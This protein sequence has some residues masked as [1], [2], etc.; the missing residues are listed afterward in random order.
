[1]LSNY[2]RLTRPIL[3][4]G[5]MIDTQENQWDITKMGSIIEN[6]IYDYIL[7]IASAETRS[8]GIIMVSEDLA[9]PNLSK[10]LYHT[11]GVY[12]GIIAEIYNVYPTLF[13]NKLNMRQASTTHHALQ[14]LEVIVIDPTLQWMFFERNRP[15]C[16]YSILMRTPKMEYEYVLRQDCLKILEAL[17]TYPGERVAK[18]F[19]DTCYLTVCIILLKSKTVGEIRTG[20]N[21]LKM[22]LSTSVGLEHICETTITIPWMLNALKQSVATLVTKPDGGIV[23]SVIQCYIKLSEDERSRSYLST[24]IPEA[25]WNQ[26]FNDVLDD[27][28]ILLKQYLLENLE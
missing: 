15:G 4:F 7:S 11:E 9:Y 1:M 18:F 21:T 22:F 20:M 5:K 26:T 12:E 25:I 13:M 27:S 10:Y 23:A 3:D 14:L 8:E 24:N 6:S 19:I 28:V 2:W 16:I 17:I